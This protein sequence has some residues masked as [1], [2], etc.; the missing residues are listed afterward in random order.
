[1]CARAFTNNSFVG[2]GR[3][4]KGTMC[5]RQFNFSTYPFTTFLLCVF[6]QC[7]ISVHGGHVLCGGGFSMKCILLWQV[8]TTFMLL[9]RAHVTFATETAQLNYI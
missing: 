8:C 4:E 2:C 5:L 3:S 9:F 7:K 1:M 6:F